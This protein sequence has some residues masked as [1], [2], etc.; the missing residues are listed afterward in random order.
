[1]WIISTYIY[2]ETQVCLFNTKFYDF[3]ILMSFLVILKSYQKLRKIKIIKDLF[4][5]LLLF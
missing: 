5:F 4:M 1:M 2:I 3:Y